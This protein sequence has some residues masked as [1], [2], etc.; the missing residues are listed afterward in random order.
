MAEPSV[1]NVARLHTLDR[2]LLTRRVG[3]LP[4]QAVRAIGEGSRL[5]PGL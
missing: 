5:V 3:S 4:A 1:V 2:A